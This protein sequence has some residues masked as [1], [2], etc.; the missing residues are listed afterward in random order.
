MRLLVTCPL[1]GGNATEKFLSTQLP[2]AVVGENRTSHAE[3]QK[4]TEYFM[5]YS[6]ISAES[7]R[8]H[9]SRRHL[10][11]TAPTSSFDTGQT[12]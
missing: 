12:G 4:Q 6:L 10:Y 5:P 8:Q 11:R 2:A 9:R 7:S 1:S 3:K